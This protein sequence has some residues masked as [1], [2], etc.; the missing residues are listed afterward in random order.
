MSDLGMRIRGLLEA[1]G[2]EFQIVDCDPE[3]ADTAVFCEHY[4]HSLAH[5]ANTIVV[6]SKTG[7]E[8][9]AA[10]L[11]LATCRLDVNKAVRKKLGARKASFASPEETQA[12][13][14]MTL[15]GVTPL[16]L[17]ASLPL[18]VDSRIMDLD[19]VILGG[20]DRA[21]KIIVDPALFRTTANTEIVPDLAK[22]AS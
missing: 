12:A 13:T 19:Y 4:G 7:E 5:S 18:W 22:E 1:S 2:L 14:G 21:S 11:V 6:R 10:C 15:G 3:L 16:A 17:P 20:G 8:K 9:Y